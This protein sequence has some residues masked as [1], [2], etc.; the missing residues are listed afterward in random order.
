MPNPPSPAAVPSTGLKLFKLQALVYD[1]L[2]RKVPESDARS[3]PESD[4][5]SVDAVV[6][7]WH[8]AT[9]PRED[10]DF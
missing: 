3:V 1:I 10:E 4:A 5:R 9:G 2:P 7:P 8:M 6:S